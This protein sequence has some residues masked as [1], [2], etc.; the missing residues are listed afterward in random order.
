MSVRREVLSSLNSMLWYGRTHPDYTAWDDFV[1][2]AYVVLGAKTERTPLE[3]RA[4]FEKKALARYTK[5]KK[6][7]ADA[8]FV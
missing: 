6:E 8:G 5:E 7:A 3:V 2:R 4:E 1:Q